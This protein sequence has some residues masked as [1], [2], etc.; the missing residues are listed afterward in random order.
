MKLIVRQRIYMALAV[1][2]IA[3]LFGGSLA[4]QYLKEDEAIV[5]VLS[6]TVQQ[7]VS[8]NENG[9]STFYHYIVGTDKGVMEIRPD[10]LFGS[11]QFG[12][13]QEGHTYRIKTRGY[14]IPLWGIYPHIIE[15]KEE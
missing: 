14:S 12:S 7:N 10:G 11:A 2:V 8:G 9:V 3:L 13:L 15:A 4:C 6:I 5:Q 1:V